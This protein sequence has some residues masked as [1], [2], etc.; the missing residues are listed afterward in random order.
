MRLASYTAIISI[1]LWATF[2][3]AQLWGG[4]VSDEIYWKISI[5][6]LLIGGGIV[7]GSLIAHECKNEKR[8]K[9]DKF[10]D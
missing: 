8:M 9:R 10:V 4:V 7:I 6:M 5:T 2:S 3:V 1:A